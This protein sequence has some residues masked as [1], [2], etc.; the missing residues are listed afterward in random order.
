MM[1]VYDKPMIYYPLSVLMMAGFSMCYIST[2]TT[3]GFSAL[4]QDGSQTRLCFQYA[5][6]RAGRTGTGIHYRENFVGKEKVA[7]I[8]A[9]IFLWPAAGYFLEHNTILTEELF[10]Y[11]VSIPNVTESLNLIQTANGFQ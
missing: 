4:A 1:P 9:T 5:F 10:S 7:L 11:H 3:R 6:S 2:R 8:L